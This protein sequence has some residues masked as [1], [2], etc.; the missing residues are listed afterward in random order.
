MMNKIDVFSI[1]DAIA[2]EDESELE[3]NIAAI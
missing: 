1:A 3:K 2:T